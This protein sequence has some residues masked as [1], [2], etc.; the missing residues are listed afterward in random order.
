MTFDPDSV[1][2]LAFDIGGTVFNWH[3]AITEAVAPLAAERGVELDAAAF[4]NDWRY[5]MFE[6]LEQV[7]LGARP[8]M[9]ADAMHRLALDDLMERYPRLGLD[10]NQ[11][12]TLNLVWHRMPAWPD[13]PPAIERLRGRYTTVV[14][15]ILSWS[16][17]VDSSKAAG[18][19]WDGIISADAIGLY[20][21]NPK[22]YEKAAE[23]L[24]LP[25]GQVMMVAAHPSDLRAAIKAGFRSAYVKPHLFDPGEDYTDTGFAE[26]FDVVA[27]DFPEL[28]RKLL[29]SG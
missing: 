19:A 10:G 9:N 28:C 5:R 23:L 29:I 13:A 11:R 22:A 16:I 6:I 14:L 8:W 17:A 15:T 26:Q 21:P 2:A 7:H 3:G 20:K 18:I 24:A 27:E 12:D 4:A 25:P 1:K